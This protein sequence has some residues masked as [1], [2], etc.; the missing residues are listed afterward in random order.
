MAKHDQE[1]REDIPPPPLPRNHRGFLDGQKF[2]LADGLNCIIGARGTGKTTVVEFVRYAMDAMPGDPNAERRVRALIER[3]LQGGRV[4][5]GVETK[6]GLN[7]I[8]S[9]SAGEE[10]MVLTE[11]GSPT[12]LSLRSGGLFRVD[13]YSQNEVESIADEA[14]AQLDL[15]DNFESERIAAIEQ[16][17][18]S[19]KADLAANANNIQPLQSKLDALKE[20]LNQLPGVEEKLEAYGSEG[21]S[22]SEA[23]NKAHALKSLRDRETRAV[24]MQ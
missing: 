15:I 22:D 12:E 11:D 2:D 5:L 18:R 4:Q 17:I 19:T 20:E 14:K 1:G 6:D 7:Y 10:P 21:G 8:I 13:V 3:N 16:Q 9:R 24:A 23:I